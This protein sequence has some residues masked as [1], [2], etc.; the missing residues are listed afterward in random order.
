MIAVHVA[1]LRARERPTSA[2]HRR[3]DAL[4]GAAAVTDPGSASLQDAIELG[5]LCA[6]QAGYVTNRESLGGMPRREVLRTIDALVQPTVF[7]PLLRALRDQVAA[8][9]SAAAGAAV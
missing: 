5:I 1:S 6:A 4:P 3:E 2:K 7:A 8:Q 9:D